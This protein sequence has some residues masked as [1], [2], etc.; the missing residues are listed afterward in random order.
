MRRRP[1]A[2]RRACPSH[3][4]RRAL[5]PAIQHLEE[6]QL[7]SL[8]AL[9]STGVAGGVPYTGEFVSIPQAFQD[10]PQASSYLAAHPAAPSPTFDAGF[11]PVVVEDGV[12][13]IIPGAWVA[14]DPAASWI[15]PNVHGQSSASLAPFVSPSDGWTPTTSSPQGLFYYTARFDVAPGSHPRLEGGSWASDNQGL[16]VFLNGVRQAEPGGVGGVSMTPFTLDQADFVDGPNTLTFVLFNEE[17]SPGRTS[18]SG[19]R[20]E[21]SIVSG[22]ATPVPT[23]SLSGRA[24]VDVN[25]DGKISPGEP[26]L[27]GVSVTLTGVRDQGGAVSARTSTTSNGSFFFFDLWPGMYA[28][29]EVPPTGYVNAKE[30][31]GNLGG[32]AGDRSFSNIRLLGSKDGTG[33]LFGHERAPQFVTKPVTLVS[34][35][36]YLSYGNSGG[37][38]T[39]GGSGGY[40]PIEYEYQAGATDA[41]KDALAYS[42]LRGPSGMAI[43]P[44]TGLVTWL[45]PQVSPSGGSGGYYSGGSGGS[46][47]SGPTSTDG[48][49]DVSLLV[50]DG[51]GGADEQDYV[52]KVIQAAPNMP[53]VWTSTPVVDAGVA[54]PYRYQGTAWDADLDGLTFS[55]AAG[56]AGLSIDANTGLV[57]WTPTEAQLGPNPVVLEVGDYHGNSA[58]QPYTIVVGQAP[59]NLPPRITSTPVPSVP[60]GQ[61][62]TYPVLAVDDDKDA[63]LNFRLTAAPASM[64]INALSGW[65][66]WPTTAADI[67]T[68]TVHVVVDDGRGGTDEQDFFIN[69]TALNEVRG[70]K[71]EDPIPLPPPPVGPP[72]QPGPIH[73]NPVDTPWTGMIAP[74]YDPTSGDLIVSVNYLANGTPNVFNLVRPDGTQ[75]PF[76]TAAGYSDEVELVSVRANNPGGFPTGD[77]FSGNGQPGQ[78]VRI[79]PGGDVSSPW[80]TLPGEYGL[81][82]GALYV[83]RTGTWGG[84]LIVVTTTG[85][86]WTVTSAGVPAKIASVGQPGTNSAPTLEGVVTVPDDP[87][88]YGPLAGDIVASSETDGGVYAIDAQGNSTYYS[89][90][91]S[92]LEA[93]ELVPADENFFGVDYGNHRLMAAPAADFAGMAG[94]FLVDQESSTD[95]SGLWRIYWDGSTLQK[96]EVTLTSDSTT[97]GS[98]EHFAFAPAGI[99]PILPTTSG[100]GLPDWTI[101]LLNSSSQVVATTTTDPNGDY[102][103]R[104]VPNG[105]YTVAEAQEPG[106]TQ[107]GPATGTYTVTLTGGQVALGNDFDNVETAGPEHPPH[108]VTTWVS[109]AQVDKKYTYDSRATDAD[110]VRLTYDLPVHPAGMVV[111]PLYGV[112]AWTP[113]PDEVGPQSVLLRVEDGRGGV[114]LQS[115]TVTV[116]PAN[117]PPAI[118]S[119]PTT[120]ALAGLTYTY[121]VRAEDPDGEKI[122]YHLNQFP[123]GMILDPNTGLLSWPNAALGT[124]HVV[125]QAADAAGLIS[126]QPF[127]LSIINQAGNDT[128]VFTSTPRGSIQLGRTYFYQ[129]VA[130]DDDHDPVTY[131]LSNPP[132]GMTISAT[133]LVSWVP[134]AAQ[135]GANSFT[136]QADDGRGGVQPQQVTVQVVA[137]E[138]NHPPTITST[139]GP[140]ATLGLPYEYDARATDVD[141][142]PL[143][144]SLVAGP[145]GMAI[146]PVSGIVLWTP[147]A[148]ELGTQPVTIR[149]DDG[150]GGYCTQSFP[151]PALGA[152]LPPQIISTP[153]TRAAQG[154]D[155]SYQVVAVDPQGDALTYALANPPAGMTINAATGLLDWPDPTPTGNQ[156]VAITVTNSQG[157]FTPQTYT[158]VLGTTAIEETPTIISKPGLYAPV[159]SPYQYPVVATSP[160]GL[161]LTYSLPNSPPSGMQINPSTGLITWTPQSATTATVTVQAQDTAGGFAS[162]TYPITAAANT[163]PTVA[164]IPAQ[165]ATVG[166]PFSYLVSAGDGDGDA[167]FTYTLAGPTGMAVD[168]AGQITWTPQAG[169]TGTKTVTVTATDAYGLSSS[170]QSFSIAVSSDVTPPQV[171]V[172]EDANPADMGT[173]VTFLVT[174]QDAVPVTS[175][176]LTVAGTALALDAHGAGRLLMPNP[177]SFAVVATATDAGGQT[178]TVTDTLAVINPADTSAPT[179]TIGS[180]GDQATV[181]APT[182]VVGTATDS[183]QLTSW[184]LAVAPVSGGPFTTINSGTQA[185]N[186]GPLGTFDPTMLA[187]GAYTIRLTAMNAGGHVAT[188]ERIVNV[189]GHLKLGNLHLSFTDL[190]IPV[191]GIP[192]TITRTYDT[193]NA[194]KQGDFGHGW[195]LSEGDFQLQVSQPDGTLGAA[196]VHAPFQAG[197]RVTL[198]RPGMDPEGFTFVP[199]QILSSIY[200]GSQFYKPFFVADPGVTDKLSVEDRGDYEALTPNG[201]G[202]FSGSDADGTPYNPADSLFGGT[203]TLTSHQGFNYVLDA[204]TGK[205]LTESDRSNNTLTFQDDGIYSNSTREVAFA[206]DPLTHDITAITDPR[207]HS[208]LYGYGAAGDLTSVTD[209][210]GNQTQF[211][212]ADTGPAHFLDHVIAPSGQVAFRANY[213]TDHRVDGLT[214]A[215]GNKTTLGYDLGSLSETA[216]APGATASTT[217]TFDTL[218]NVTGAVDADGNAASATYLG[219]DLASQTRTVNGQ[220]LTTSYTYDQYGDVLTATDPQGHKTY[221]SYDQF[222]QPTSSA[223]ALGNATHFGFDG[224]GNLTSTTSPTGVTTSTSYFADGQVQATTTPDGMTSYT[225]D[226]FGDVQT[227]IDPRGTKTT[228][229]YDANGNQTSSSW[230]WVDPNDASHKVVVSTTNIYDNNDHL[231]ETDAPDG[232]TKTYY[233]ADSRAYETIDNLGGVT[234]TAFDADGRAVRTTAPDGQVSDTVYDARGR[235]QWADDP[236]LPGQPA[237]GTYTTYDDT[238]KV[239][240]TGRFAAV[241]IT[242]SQPAGAPAT[243]GFVSHGAQLSS[244]STTYDASGRVATSTDAAGHTTTYKYDA[245]G[246]QIEVDDT[247]N[248]AARSTTSAYD[249]V[250]RLISTTDALNHA[251]TYK[252]DADGRQVEVDDPDGTSSKTKYDAVGRKVAAIDQAGA[253]T[254]YQYDALGQ[255]TAV[256]LPAVTATGQ[257]ARPTTHYTYDVYG[258]LAT[259]SDPLAQQHYDMGGPPT[260]VPTIS[261]TYDAFGRKTSET[262]ATLADGTTPTETW[263]YNGLGQLASST[264]FNGNVTDD[265]YDTQGRLATKAAYAK[266]STTAYDTVTYAYDTP[267]P[268]G[269]GGHSD[270]VSS[271]L[272]GATTSSYDV[273]GNLVR[274]TSPQGTIAYAYDPATGAKT[275]VTTT[276]TDIR[277]AYND[278]GQLTTVTADRLDGQAASQVTTYAYDA[279]GNLLTTTLPNNTVETRAYDTLNRL[280]S[281]ATTDG[282][283]GPVVFSAT[284]A[285]DA[286]GRVTVAME[287]Q[288]G[289]THE[290]D[291]TYDADG[292][293]LKETIDP[294]SSS[295]RTLSYAYDLAGNRVAS[296]DS[297]APSAQQYLS[298]TYDADGRLTA[299]QGAYGGSGGPGYS[300]SST[301]DAAGNTTTTTTGSQVVTN[302]WDPEG[303]LVGVVTTVNGATTQTVSYTYDADGNR[304]SETVDGQAT[305]FL[306]DPNQAYDQ[307]LEE[308][309]P[310]GALAA[311]YVR[312]LD[313]LFQDRSAAGGGTGLSYYAVD[314]LGSTR[315]LTNASGA[316]TDTYTYD[317]YGNLIAS[318]GGTINPYQ[319]AGQRLDAG[320]GQYD[321]GARV[322][323]ASAGQFASRDSYDGTTSDPITQNHYAYASADPVD[324]TDPTGMFTQK[325]GYLAEAAIYAVYVQDHPGQNVNPV[326][327]W[328]K[329]GK[330]PALAYR[331]KPDILNFSAQTW[332]EIKPLSTSGVAKAGVQYLAYSEVFKPFGYSPDASWQPSTHFAMAGNLEIAFFNAGGIIFYTDAT[333][334]FEDFVGLSSLALV[335]SFMVSPLGKRLAQSIIVAFGDRIPSLVALRVSGDGARLEG[336]LGIGEIF[337]AMGFL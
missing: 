65:I 90:G 31:V 36:Q 229:A 300:V 270:T 262:L 138:V 28:L 267:D 222:G 158:L 141:N 150:Q 10:D 190:A 12:Y 202:T 172:Q 280:A 199:Q 230:T 332:A 32:T 75:V 227:V 7:L 101:N 236:H 173:V 86:V 134:T 153:D 321:M 125:V 69:V 67:G 155:Y 272:S 317:P 91:L 157:A 281:I 59:G 29:A 98:W 92:N 53:P 18:P 82:R 40:S 161:T 251:T 213:G 275:G 315:A 100:P 50:S 330:Y 19:I 220:A 265:T 261:Y 200:T 109:T 4:R 160:I 175:M 108:F 249:V 47:G 16:A 303:H 204:G 11:T 14:D 110:H 294:N 335:N 336:A 13:P 196:G 128:P 286:D 198:T 302:T 89:L 212:Y 44:R 193:L 207:N 94:Q 26:P 264:D 162:Q 74:Q 334:S 139:P 232:V 97:P 244:T 176:T 124:F 254:D 185:V 285:R 197:T 178:G 48:N 291:Y 238:G 290:Y 310:G 305:T 78:I 169:D 208:I 105:T 17:Y 181:T 142:D 195:T 131:A 177:G 6:R 274:V 223:D 68:H 167:A 164:A 327:A 112:V 118:T 25:D 216:T 271:T 252:Y 292:R 166:A 21:G 60:G 43:N 325:I 122:T 242:V 148:D 282:V 168:A 140:I 241:V 306:N 77:V 276:S 51:R 15:A 260:W 116:A 70:R 34:L 184:T 62:Y 328:A 259:E 174:A 287:N 183:V 257:S 132:A 33:Y 337:A 45:P 55:V 165:S 145:T 136:V 187:N 217:V 9:L 104:D 143:S 129:P 71:Y 297:G 107:V 224:N 113:T 52:L 130:V 215:L 279:A 102:A 289:A 152:P 273:H 301:Y 115:F 37:T 319:Y 250:G 24:Y 203:F 8:T 23:G 314:H 234:L 63:P 311:T 80:V 266:G 39:S 209:R 211:V 253:E 41:D 76:S 206:R 117:V 189:A 61:L 284:Y 123:P 258:N 188:D 126:I 146:D 79:S 58:L 256:L 246:R 191:A 263:A 96:A 85:N 219:N 46:G 159:G 87:A 103:F 329:L 66:A 30:T 210:D 180:P 182:P 320:T 64:T 247:A 114:D 192:I 3:A 179:A 99:G 121:P 245:S 42:L 201:D 237:D 323:N 299:I 288:G 255:L 277:Y 296:T 170:P 293:L 231:I 38:G 304:T 120:T 235:V 73:L 316:V 307:V 2:G 218:G 313:L 318:T 248:G 308:Y 49:Y 295:P 81:L 221:F 127:D 331:L 233:D 309:A 135:F 154:Q 171:Q 269:D 163:A 149:V 194:N 268:D 147:T 133:G 226:P 326:G 240:A 93:I 333:D 278:L 5:L 54:T 72:P 106:W 324:N 27:G 119:R 144:W 243:S 56:P 322:Y 20:V 239:Q 35:P 151:L 95:T 88:T 57:K 205:I 84:D 298:D 1:P 225:Y 83:D 312:G 111:D 22:G 137:Q 228:Y 186:S 214:D 283:A 156:S